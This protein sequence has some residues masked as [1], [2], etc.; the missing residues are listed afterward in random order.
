MARYEHLPIYRRRSRDHRED[1]A[2]P[3]T[4]RRRSLW[5]QAAGAPAIYAPL[6]RLGGGGRV[7][8][9]ACKAIRP[10]RDIAPPNTIERRK[11]FAERCIILPWYMLASEA[12]SAHSRET[13]VGVGNGFTV[14]DARQARNH[15]DSPL[16]ATTARNRFAWTLAVPLLAPALGSVARVSQYSFVNPG[17]LGAIHSVAIGSND[18]GQVTGC[19][20]A[21]ELFPEY[22]YLCSNSDPRQ[23]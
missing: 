12:V 21:A 10:S 13:V 17:R 18:I 22:A 9:E 23:R 5:A 15:L 11:H 8:G 14:T 1:S 16:M 19:T 6:S 7:S 3:G 20:T 2:A 4:R